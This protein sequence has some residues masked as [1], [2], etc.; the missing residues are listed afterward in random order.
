M[1]GVAGLAPRTPSPRCGPTAGC[2]AHRA[3]DQ[4]P[5]RDSSLTMPSK[6]HR[7]AALG[8]LTRYSTSEQLLVTASSDCTVR[9]WQPEDGVCYNVFEEMSSDVVACALSTKSNHLVRTLPCT[10]LTHAH[11]LR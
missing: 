4:P 6:F 8:S 11:V 1:L 2:D 5:S 3:V 10:T 7:A 9:V